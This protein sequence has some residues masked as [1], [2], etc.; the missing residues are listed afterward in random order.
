ML[1]SSAARL[2]V[3]YTLAF[4]LSALVLAGLVLLAVHAAMAAQ[5]DDRIRSDMATMTEEYH[6]GIGELSGVIVQRRAFGDPVLYGLD[7]PAGV[8]I[9]EL[10]GSGATTGWS[11]VTIGSQKPRHIRVLTQNLDGGYR[12]M[13]GDDLARIGDL[14]SLVLN[15]FAWWLA[16]A[17]A[18]GGLGGLL[19]GRDLH[20]RL[21]ALSQVAQAVADGD[22]RRR[23][24]VRNTSDDLDSLAR[25]FNAM[26][27]QVT[28]LMESLKQVSQD[29]AHDLRT[30]LWRLRQQLERALEEGEGE[31]RVEAIQR[32]MENL[33]II[34][35]TF[36]AILRIAQIDSGSLRAGF[37]ELDLAELARSVVE[38]LE[39]LAEE[40]GTGLTLVEE[41]AVRALGDRELL[42]QL[43]I[44]LI[45]N[46]LRHAGAG[47]HVVVSAGLIDDRPTLVVTDD[48]PGIPAADRERVFERFVRLEQSRT[49]AGSGL[50]L[51]LVQSIARLH[52]GA[53]QLS[54]AEPGLRATVSLGSL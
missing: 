23:A 18:I 26:L 17:V 38:T 20:R 47:R 15:R 13:V 41:G 29:V 54:D 37:V 30:P 25:T 28:T 44:N 1:R 36:T 16:G 35:R 22:L 21:G 27:D 12:L 52:G 24:Q 6:E 34:L 46:G 3:F 9:G 43:L 50:G 31:A 49:T 5:F 32:A 4:S 11:S 40:Q 45:D 7:G 39:P 51:A 8:A 33:D 42:S 19:V 48:G 14:D 53:C 2:A 10:A